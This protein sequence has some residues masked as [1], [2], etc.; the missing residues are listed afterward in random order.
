MIEEK[1]I[2]LVHILNKLKSFIS[3]KIYSILISLLIILIGVWVL[4]VLK[5][6]EFSSKVVISSNQYP[7]SISQEILNELVEAV[8][9][10]DYDLLYSKLGIQSGDISTIKKMNLSE[11]RLGENELLKSAIGI[12]FTVQDK[13]NIVR[14]D[15]VIVNFMNE[16]GFVQENVKSKKR[17]LEDYIRNIMGQIKRLDSTQIY[18]INKLGSTNQNMSIENFDLGS[19][20]QQ[21]IFMDKELNMSKE[22]LENLIEFKV[23]SYIEVTSKL[24]LWKYLNMGL[25]IWTV[26]LM[27]LFVKYIW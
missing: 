25:I 5:P 12:D 2:D 17:S 26:F 6:K 27:F 11:V 19:I 14:L 9:N 7:F 24:L 8:N 1:D 13:K 22:E 20:Y 21:M 15:T 3:N 4:N 23:V 18:L 10:E 16:V